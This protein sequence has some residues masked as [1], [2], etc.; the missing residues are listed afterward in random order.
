MISLFT[1]TLTGQLLGFLITPVLSRLYSPSDFGMFQLFISIVGMTASF[2]TLSYYNA[3]LLPERDEDSAN[4]VV[5]CLFLVTV[6]AVVVTVV[7]FLSSAFLEKFLN[8]PGLSLYLPLIPIAIGFNGFAYVLGN[9]LSKKEE[10]GTIAKANILS[11]FT[12]KGT[13]AGIGFIAP[14]PFGLILATI[15]N[16][17][18]ICLI[19]GRKVLSGLA[20][21]SKTSVKRIRE[22]AVRYKKFPLYSMGSDTAG[23]AAVQ[24]APFLLA[25][26][27]SPVI[28]GYYSMAYLVMRLPTKMIGTAIA[29][30][31]F[32]RASAEKN[33]TGS[34][35][36]VV[37]AV[38]TRLISLG[39]FACLLVMVLG[40]E[41]FSFLLGSHWADAGVYA[42]VFAPWFFVSFISVPLVYIFSV[43]EKQSVGL[44]FSLLQLVASIIAL[45]IGGLSDSPLVGMILLSAT[46]VVFWGWMN[47]YSLE[48]AGVPVRESA[49]EIGKYF[50]IAGCFCLPIAIAKLAAF[51]S[52]FLIAA[53]VLLALVYYSGVIYHDVQLRTG[54]TR[55]AGDLF[56]RVKK[57]RSPP[58]GVA[59]KT[60]FSGRGPAGQVYP[61]P[62][63]GGMDLEG[64]TKAIRHQN[65]GIRGRA[66]L[67]LGE[68][69]EP[70]VR[71]LIR[72][73]GEPDQDVRWLAGLTLGK[74]GSP[75]IPYL[76]RALSEDDRDLR[77]HASRILAGIG[78]PAVAP[79]LPL[80][81]ERD[82][83]VQWHS[84]FA[85]SRIGDPAVGPLIL[86]LKDADW[87]VRARVA[88]AL[89][90]IRDRRAIE[91]LIQS[92]N[93]TDWTVRWSAADALG[94]INDKSAA[95]WLEKAL[96]EPDSYVQVPASWAL[97]KLGS[98]ASVDELIPALKNPDWNVRWSAADALGTIGEAR[99]LYPLTQVKDDPD[100]DE[101]VRKAAEN[102]IRKILA[103]TQ[104]DTEYLSAWSNLF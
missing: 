78:R 65:P 32:Q 47:M 87:S 52:L 53:A 4:L 7:F 56:G 2:A 76:I 3:I 49:R 94:K 31:F 73:L 33:R 83:D 103:G 22:L 97:G 64:L 60:D 95:R 8:A 5:L 46:G 93:D 20:V 39:M 42:Q 45:V 91:P 34:M 50:V 13:S 29:T 63:P 44:W 86:L 37:T 15:V 1:S 23:S 41:L 11:S 84:A 75:A 90:E 67:A 27:F 25:F 61:L 68:I 19:Q 79:L 24:T 30:V 48:L 40:P 71:P 26:F 9:W 57:P 6:T 89:G 96:R 18:T 55:F 72:A 77:W 38:H 58:A 102:A 51:P 43:L 100:E 92:V 66:A 81:R 101:L 70:A 62:D 59:G 82:S 14:S 88:W 99:A 21:F 80:L 54:F 16:D 10:F 104:K 35:K 28:V 74:I 98:S 69:G 12:G 17:G 36:H 85:L